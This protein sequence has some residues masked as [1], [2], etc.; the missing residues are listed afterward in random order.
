MEYVFLSPLIVPAVV[1]GFALLS[2]FSAIDGRQPIGNLI[3]AHVLVTIPFT[4]RASWSSMA[5]MDISLEE[6]AYSLGA[7]PWS[8]FWRVTLPLIRPGI[9]AGA[10][11]AFTYSFN[12]VAVSIFLVGPGI[13][14]L[15]VEMMSQIS[16]SSDP[17]PAAVS[18]IMIFVTLAFFLLADRTVGLGI[19]SETST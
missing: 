13:S 5:G 7:N 3:V 9:V 6:A 8:A 18:S 16:Y 10:I 14:T 4:I 17:T 2:F 19:F 15:P 11:L 1:V 12:D